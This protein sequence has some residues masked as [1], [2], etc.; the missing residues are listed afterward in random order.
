MANRYRKFLL[1]LLMLSLTGCSST[2]FVYNRLDFIIP[3]YLGKYVDLERGQKSSLDQLLD[4]F[5]AWHRTEELPVYLEIVDEML[6]TLDGEITPE[7]IAAI[8]TQFEQAWLRIEAR[9]LEWMISLGE[10]LSDEQ[11]AEFIDKLWEKQAEY[12]EEYLTRSDQEFREETY[13]NLKDSVQDYLGRLD[14]DQRTMLDE[15]TKKL[16]RSDAIWLREREL[17]L[18]RL[19]E[20]LQREEDWQQALRDSLANREQTTSA[21][22]H[23][24]Y[25]HNAR[26]LYAA[27]A[28]VL[29]VRTDPQDKRLRKK[30]ED[31][32][33]DIE[34]LME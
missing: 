23:E 28:R 17:W 33:E 32:R 7:Q 21:E 25:E 14:W 5:L 13:D 11:M 22:Y 27:I 24:V 6:A 8:A 1:T 31:L 9:G 2:T 12:E 4:P 20:I 30:L 15:A 26:V 19:G 18:E 34:T 10:E 29:N 3:W 16:R